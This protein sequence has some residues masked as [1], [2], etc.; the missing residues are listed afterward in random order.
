MK[1]Y[2]Q[3]Y[4]VFLSSERGLSQNT[5]QSY[6]RDV[7]DALSFLR[8]NGIVQPEQVRRQHLSLYLAELRRQ[9]RKGS[10]I[11]RKTASIRSFFRYLSRSGVISRDPSAELETQ[12]RERKLPDILTVAEIDKLLNAP[13]RYTVAGLRDRAMLEL[14]YAAGLRVSELTELDL[15]SVQPA[16]GVIRCTGRGGKER[17]V[18]LGQAAATALDDYLR[19]A[20]PALERPGGSEPALFLNPA[21]LRMSRQGFWKIV[22]KYARECGIAS[23][24]TPHTLRHSFAAHLIA[25]GADLRSVQDLMGHTDLSATQPY[26]ALFP[27]RMKEIYDKAHPR[28]RM[29]K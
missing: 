28:A 26:A 11:A 9:G 18:P 6:S 1:T 22:K 27:A 17:I 5:V 19:H 8:E 13:P 3:S 10:T 16:L 23:N 21:G 25:G 2:L 24:I 20:R 29:D 14:L 7:E 15:D 12:K 4:T